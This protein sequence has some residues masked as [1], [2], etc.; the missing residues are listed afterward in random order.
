MDIIK[1][2]EYKKSR[3]GM[4]IAALGSV[5]TSMV[6]IWLAVSGGAG[7]AASSLIVQAVEGVDGLLHLASA[8]AAKMEECA[9]PL[10]KEA[11]HQRTLK[12]RRRILSLITFGAGLTGAYAANQIVHHEY[13]PVTTSAIAVSA[14]AV[15][16]NALASSKMHNYAEHGTPHRDS[17]RHA[18]GDAVVGTGMT[19]ALGYSQLTGT[20]WLPSATALAG[21]AVIATMN[22]PTQR[23][24]EGDHHDHAE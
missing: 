3:S 8:R 10:E 11:V 18:L 22:F 14:A 6:E 21:S 17:W 24:I 7:G 2:P 23:R 9:L 13:E 16:I 4:Y 12:M 5:G 19:A 1:D 15:A 20:E